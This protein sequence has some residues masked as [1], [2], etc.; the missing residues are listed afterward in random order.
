MKNEISHHPE[1]FHLLLF[2]NT[3]SKQI[4]RS[5]FDT[6]QEPRESGDI[7]TVSDHITC[8]TCICISSE[9]EI[10]VYFLVCSNLE[11]NI[12]STALDKTHELPL[13]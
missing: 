5:F 2:D 7:S 9:L 11:V 10:H 1:S 6:N 12:G 3:E 8:N 4:Q 13:V